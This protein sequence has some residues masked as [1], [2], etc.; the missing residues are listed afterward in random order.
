MK[1]NN[2]DAGLPFVLQGSSLGLCSK[3]QSF[4]T[5][6]N[7][8]C[9]C[10]RWGARCSYRVVLKLVRRGFV[11]VNDTPWLQVA[12]IA[13]AW[14]NFKFSPFS[15]ICPLH[16]LAT[17][18]KFEINLRTSKHKN[19]CNHEETNRTER[20]FFPP[21]SPFQLGGSADTT[22]IGWNWLQEP[23]WGETRGA[24]L[25]WVMFLTA[26]VTALFRVLAQGQ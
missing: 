25:R 2:G 23:E 21:P 10:F 22:F 19:R 14:L 26:L 13:Q 5:T 11:N 12:H 15:C 16:A 9:P 3:L 8:I 24:E 1:S 4:F 20:T 18:L 7:L 6:C 17:S